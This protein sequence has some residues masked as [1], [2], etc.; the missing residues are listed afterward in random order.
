MLRDVVLD[1]SVAVVVERGLAGWTLERV[2][3]EVKCAK[4][5]VLYHYQSKARLL[6]LTAAEL[7]RVRWDLRLAAIGRGTGLEAIDRL[8]GALVDDVESGRF[9][10]WVSLAAGG[11][12]GVAAGALGQDFHRALPRVLGLPAE[13][14]ADPASIDAMLDGIELS[15]SRAA[16]RAPIRTAYD[17]LWTSLVAL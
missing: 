4:G 6:A 11:H 17:R 8:W 10:A 1:R 16:S 12:A 3:L 9:A 2:A 15:L 13:S 7:E 14:L 5:L